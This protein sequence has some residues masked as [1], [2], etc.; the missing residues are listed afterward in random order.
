MEDPSLFIHA[1]REICCHFSLAAAG[2]VAA[3]RKP[4]FSEPMP[5]FCQKRCLLSD[6]NR[7]LLIFVSAGVKMG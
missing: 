1:I 6:G 5:W 3:L 7:K 2:C 4:V